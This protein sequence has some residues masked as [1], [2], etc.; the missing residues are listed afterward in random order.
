MLCSVRMGLT[1]GSMNEYPSVLLEPREYQLYFLLART[2]YIDL[3]NGFLF[4]SLGSS[5]VWYSCF[6]F[7]FSIF[8][9]DYRNCLQCRQQI[10]QSTTQLTA[11]VTY[12]SAN[13]CGTLQYFLLSYVCYTTTDSVALPAIKL[14]RNVSLL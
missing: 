2:K 1:G 11:Q 12:S 13:N 4:S 3:K 9:F 10:L 14:Q 5:T 6:F 8:H 7:F